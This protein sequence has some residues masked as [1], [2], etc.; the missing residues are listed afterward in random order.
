MI[1][2]STHESTMKKYLIAASIICMSHALNASES[3]I[4]LKDEKE[5][6]GSA[7]PSVQPIAKPNINF[8]SV[9]QSFKDDRTNSEIS[10]TV[11]GFGGQTFFKIAAV[12]GKLLNA[13]QSHSQNEIQKFHQAYLDQMEALKLQQQETLAQELEALNVKHQQKLA[14]ELEALQAKHREALMQQQSLSTNTMQSAQS[15]LLQTNTLTKALS[16]AQSDR[17]TLKE[18]VKTLQEELAAARAQ[19]TLLQ[20]KEDQ[21]LQ[22]VDKSS[23]A[24]AL[25]KMRKEKLE[26]E[27]EQLQKIIADIA[28]KENEVARLLRE[29]DEKEQSLTVVTGSL[30]DIEQ[31]KQ[32]IT[33]VIERT[34]AA[35]ERL[36]KEKAALESSKREV[37]IRTQKLQQAIKVNDYY[38]QIWD[39]I[40]DRSVKDEDLALFIWSVKTVQGRDLDQ[41]SEGRD[42]KKRLIRALIDVSHPRDPRPETYNSA[43]NN[44]FR[45][46]GDDFV[47]NG[48][49]WN[50]GATID[51]KKCL[52]EGSEFAKKGAEHAEH[53]RQLLK[54]H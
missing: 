34:K 27:N 53:A 39:M 11:F 16:E 22:E 31:T 12:D 2:K 50:G 9:F 49:A 23:A 5:I 40:F 7:Q 45:T 18:Q 14:T 28:T 38:T 51:Y 4:E 30:E 13:V 32:G 52:Y 17:D 8:N 47:P 6:K 25:E 29:V 46:L 26:K 43:Y 37:E 42:E 1:I 21:L 44:S 36:H 10:G 41:L 20:K 24:T 3:Y 35:I 54:N 19:A 48:L 33:A 15:A